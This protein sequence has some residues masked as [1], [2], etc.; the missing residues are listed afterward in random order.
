LIGQIIKLAPGLAK[1]RR[2]VSLLQPPKMHQCANQQPSASPLSAAKR[3]H[4]IGRTI[5][6]A[7]R[8]TET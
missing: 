6:T 2:L 5:C 7:F 3:N 8:N 4:P 1:I